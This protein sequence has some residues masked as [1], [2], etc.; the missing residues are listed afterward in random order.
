MGCGTKTPYQNYSEKIEQMYAEIITVRLDYWQVKQ[1]VK[2]YAV[3]VDGV[4]VETPHI[5]YM[6]LALTLF[7]DT[8]EA[9][10]YAMCLAQGKINL[11]YPCSEWSS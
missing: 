4:V 6:G 2:K 11:P 5:G 10:E 8:D 9:R 7:W 1:W 3:K